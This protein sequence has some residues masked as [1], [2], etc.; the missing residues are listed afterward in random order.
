MTMLDERPTSRHIL[1][2][3]MRAARLDQLAAGVDYAQQRLDRAVLAST[4]SL[5]AAQTLALPVMAE[6]ADDPPGTPD[7]EGDIQT[8]GLF[9][10]GVDF[11]AA[12]LQRPDVN[13]GGL[14]IERP[15]LHTWVAT[16]E[17]PVAA[18][19]GPLYVTFSVDVDFMCLTPG[20]QIRGVVA[21]T[22]LRSGNFL[23]IDWPIQTAQFTAV[24]Q[25]ARTDVAIS[26]PVLAG[27][28][29]AL[30]LTY[31][32]VLFTGNGEF[33]SQGSFAAHRTVAGVPTQADY[34]M[35]DYRFVPQWWIDDVVKL[36][37]S[38]FEG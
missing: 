28:Q 7:T 5:L 2:A 32:M 26:L 20:A 25:S 1:E 29:V 17:F 11:T 22:T 19:P 15:W 8:L 9:S 18:A 23:E 27:Q 21:F 38:R 12:L 4:T 34:G 31:G 13:P 30:E 36:S 35:V 6:G 24:E 10:G 16:A 3:T 14:P 33:E 37:G